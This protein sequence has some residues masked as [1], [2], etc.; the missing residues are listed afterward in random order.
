MRKYMYQIFAR[1]P[2]KLQNEV[3]IT[4]SGVEVLSFNKEL[5]KQELLKISKPKIN[6]VKTS[7]KE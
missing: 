7:E 3:R 6:E 1:K 2:K 4:P 5:V